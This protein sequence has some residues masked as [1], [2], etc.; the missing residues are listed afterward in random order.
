MQNTPYETLICRPYRVAQI[1]SAVA[2][3][4]I[5]SPL[6]VLTTA[7]GNVIRNAFVVTPK[8]V[9]GDVSGFTQ[10]LNIGTEEKPKWVIDGRPYMRWERRDDT[11]R[12]V[13]E[14]DFSFQCARIALSLQAQGQGSSIFFGF[15]DLP[16]KTFTRWITLAL[17]QRYGLSIE[18][19]IAISVIAAYY[20]S[21]RLSDDY[22]ISAEDIMPLTQQVSRVC[23]VPRPRALE[24]GEQ[25]ASKKGSITFNTAEDLATAIAEFSG[26]VRLTELRFLDLYTIIAGSWIGV[27]ARENV[28]VAIEHI[29]TWIALV[30]SALDENSYRKTILAKRAE[31]TG[32]PADIKL[33]TSQVFQQIAQSFK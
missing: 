25:L 26:S 20:Y 2:R 15:G 30:Y 18:Q 31:T 5:E 6:P 11:Y 23:M 1:A 22:T 28:G 24:I 10:F 21:A 7:K 17:S 13:A 32:R 19:Q 16:I 9:Y 29:P 8:D 12:L 33:F 27:N 3:A 4:D 14:N